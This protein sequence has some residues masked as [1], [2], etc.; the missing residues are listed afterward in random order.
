MKRDARPKLVKT[1][2]P[3]HRSSGPPS[4]R[5]D[6]QV[7]LAKA[8]ARADHSG[9]MLGVL[10]LD[11]DDFRRIRDTVGSDAGDMLLDE[12]SQR[13]KNTL[14]EEDTFTRIG[15]GS[16]AIL[17]STLSQPEN[18]VSAAKRILNAMEK[19]VRYGAHE[20]ILKCNIGISVY[21][22]DDDPETLVKNAA[23]AMYRAREAGTHRYRLYSSLMTIRAEEK[24]ALESSLRRA[25]EKKQF[26]LYYQPLVNI[27]TGRIEAVEALLRWIHPTLGTV[28]PAE[29]LPIAEE[30][31]FIVPLGEWILKEACLQIRCWKKAGHRF[32]RLCVNIS[33]RQL[34]QRDFG[35]TVERILNETGLEPADLELELTENIIME[36]VEQSIPI[37]YDLKARGLKFS[38][39]D[40]GTGYSSL[41]SIRRFPIQA[42]K[43]DRSFVKD[44]STDPDDRAIVQAMISMAHKLNLRVIAEGVETEAQ[45][46]FL[47]AHRCDLIQGFLHSKPLPAVACEGYLLDRRRRKR[48]RVDGP[49]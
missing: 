19:P 41:G 4:E 6:F 27:E 32:L 18:G 42:I 30:T 22:G 28:Y 7:R 37:L 25:L 10:F 43:I 44:V 2:E 5:S 39:D 45:F 17:L 21:P 23:T 14:Y 34:M 1:Y 48:R 8:M 15:N 46:E 9:Q 26:C 24:L 16:Y 36:R 33:G 49:E 38:I 47:K 3:E 29:F 13:L 31:G 12:I 40:F 20:L 11:F 35:R